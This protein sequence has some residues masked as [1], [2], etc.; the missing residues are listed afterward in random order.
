MLGPDDLITEVLTA[1][2][3]TDAD[4]I[5]AYRDRIDLLRQMFIHEASPGPDPLAT[6]RALFAWLW[7]RKPARYRM[8]AAYRL[9]EVIEAEFNPKEDTVGNCLGLTVLYNCLLRGLGV[10]ARAVFLEWAFGIG[11]HV[12]SLIEAGERSIDVENILPHGFDYRGHAAAAGRMIWNDLE[13]IA[14]IYHSRGND[15]FASG[16]Y[17]QALQMYDLALQ[18][19]PGYEKARLNQATVLD[20]L[21]HGECTDENAPHREG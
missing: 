10:P 2:G 11:P 3:I 18:W 12:L 14:D 21:Y 9:H 15:Y 20:V 4:R 13:L 6:A 5:A 7:A 17:D 16:C 8:G 1:S 19:N